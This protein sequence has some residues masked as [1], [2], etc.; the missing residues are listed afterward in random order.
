MTQSHDRHTFDG[1]LEGV[2]RTEHHE[3]AFSTDW[4]EIETAILLVTEESETLG[5]TLASFSSR[6]HALEERL[7]CLCEGDPVREHTEHH[8]VR[9]HTMMTIL[10][11]RLQESTS[12]LHRI[13]HLPLP[14][15][16]VHEAPDRLQ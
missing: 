12:V 16:H 5:K 10:E 4:H 1:S 9:L 11:D 3:T 8:L 15:E 6:A 2:A 13:L 7:A 14:F